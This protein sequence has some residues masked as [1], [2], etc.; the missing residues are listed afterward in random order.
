MN[1][2]SEWIQNKQ[3]NTHLDVNA[4]QLIKQGVIRCCD[5][6][7]FKQDF[8]LHLTKNAHKY[9]ASRVKP[10]TFVSA[11]LLNF[12]RNYIRKLNA[13]KRNPGLRIYFSSEY[14]YDQ[15][16]ESMV[17]VESLMDHKAIE[18]L[19]G[20]VNEEPMS[21]VECRDLVE[22]I[23]SLLEP[24]ELD[25]ILQI[26]RSSVKQT[27]EWRDCSRHVVRKER[28]RIRWKVKKAGE[29]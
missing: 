15:E 5:G 2:A 6:D 3:I 14:C 7:D 23:E 4:K 16:T 12:I 20:V 18:R 22:Y 25:L 19:T 13:Q 1:Q 11:V 8:W 9:D 24:D 29:S 17:L 21:Q 28:D 10:I 26:N 27:A